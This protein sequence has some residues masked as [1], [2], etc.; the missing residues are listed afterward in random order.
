MAALFA[1]RAVEAQQH[2]AALKHYAAQEEY[3]S[4]T[5]LTCTNAGVSRRVAVP[6]YVPPRW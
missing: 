6:L 5:G 3:N 4:A 1:G 2:L